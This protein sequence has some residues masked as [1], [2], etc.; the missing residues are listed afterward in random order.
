M[1]RQNFVTVPADPYTVVESAQRALFD[2]QDAIVFFVPGEPRGKARAR[3]TVMTRRDGSVVMGKNG[4]PVVRH[5]T[6][7]KT[8]QGERGIATWFRDAHTGPM[9][10][11]PVILLIEVMHVPTQTWPTWKRSMVADQSMLP[12]TKPDGD[13]IR[14][15]VKDALNKVAWR[16]DTQVVMAIDLKRYHHSPGMRIG[17]IPLR[18]APSTVKFKRDALSYL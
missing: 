3:S 15:L 1:A 2:H 17:I 16:D 12:V 10:E 18:R 4:R 7:D 8:V 9:M 14:K 13:N 6:P 5:Y 11:C